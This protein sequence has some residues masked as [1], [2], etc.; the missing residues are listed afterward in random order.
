[1]N[2]GELVC[3][4]NPPALS[5]SV[6]VLLCLTVREI[7]LKKPQSLK[8]MLKLNTLPMLIKL[9]S[10]LYKKPRQ[11]LLEEAS[12]GARSGAR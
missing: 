8:T 9:I 2:R 1:M 11:E 7:E 10:G 3:C 6:H 5:H 12:P 4:G